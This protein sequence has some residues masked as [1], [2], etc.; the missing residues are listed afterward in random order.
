[1]SSGYDIGGILSSQAL[2]H[3]PD[4]PALQTCPQCGQALPNHLPVCPLLPPSPAMSV[5]AVGPETLEAEND[6]QKKLGEAI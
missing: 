4:G 2:T 5:P 3:D 6:M 1:M